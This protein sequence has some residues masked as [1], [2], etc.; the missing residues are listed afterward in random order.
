MTDPL[1]DILAPAVVERALSIYESF[2]DRR[3]VDI[4]QARNW[5]FKEVMDILRDG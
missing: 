3:H 5:P 1:D 4:V 2:R